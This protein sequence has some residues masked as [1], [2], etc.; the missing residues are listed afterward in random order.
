MSDAPLSTESEKPDSR[1]RFRR[2]MASQSAS[3]TEDAQEANAQPE[4]QADSRPEAALR[5]EAD[6]L[7]EP[8]EN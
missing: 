8:A 1:A 4:P 5:P 6:S 7:P 2:L 3:P